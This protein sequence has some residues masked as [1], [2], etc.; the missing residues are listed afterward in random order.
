MTCASTR[1]FQC[2]GKVRHF[3]SVEC[4]LAHKKEKPGDVAALYVMD[5]LHAGEF[6][7]LT[8]HGQPAVLVQSENQ[9]AHG[10]GIAAVRS[11][12]VGIMVEKFGAIGAPHELE[13]TLPERSAP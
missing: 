7:S 4:A 8:G 13:K 5:F 1:T 9:I 6:L 12:D 2:E 11:A 3:D 10:C